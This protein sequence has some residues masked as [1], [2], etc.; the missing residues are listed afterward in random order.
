MVNNKKAFGLL[1]LSSWVV[2]LTLSFQNCAPSGA[3]DSVATSSTGSGG[4][5][6][7]SSSSYDGYTVH[8]GSS[9]YTYTPPATTPSTDTTTPSTDSSTS[10]STSTD[11]A[12]SAFSYVF[13][14]A[15]QLQHKIGR[16]EN[17]GWSVNTSQDTADFMIYGPYATNWGKGETQAVFRLTADNNT[18]TDMDVVT[19]DIY[20]ATAGQIVTRRTIRRQELPPPHV[21]GEYILNF[22]MAER[23]GHRMETRVY[24]HGVSYLNVQSVTVRSVLVS[25][26]VA[27]QLPHRIG[28]VDKDGWATDTINEPDG[29]FLLYG[30]YIE[31]LPVGRRRALYRVMVDNHTA[32]NDEIFLLDIWDATA[33]R[34]IAQ[35]WVRRQE[36]NSA[37]AYNELSL[38]FD[39]DATTASHKIETRLFAYG[40][41][42][43]RVD[44]VSIQ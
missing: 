12:I 38:D 7:S 27:N 3:L 42:Y 18:A 16:G 8:D 5:N 43:A 21:M 9:S 6:N 35:R 20:D 31:N 34:A 22:S 30:P 37:W 11:P 41:T 2:I 36:L 14:A 13:A 32:N 10:P 19:I 23:E 39:L 44:Y 25:Y 28:R 1:I 29:G 17:N 40:R 24:S 4:S 26:N 15:S 33:G